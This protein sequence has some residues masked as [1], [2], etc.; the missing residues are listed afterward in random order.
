M[1]YLEEAFWLVVV[2]FALCVLP[3]MVLAVVALWV[4]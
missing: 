2:L 4:S 3:A 1:R